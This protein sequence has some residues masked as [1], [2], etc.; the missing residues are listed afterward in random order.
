VYEGAMIMT[1]E[2]PYRSIPQIYAYL[3][4]YIVAPSSQVI[5]LTDTLWKRMRDTY[6]KLFWRSPEDN[7]LNKW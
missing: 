1:Y 6:P 3:D 7:K 2:K 5:G 4:K